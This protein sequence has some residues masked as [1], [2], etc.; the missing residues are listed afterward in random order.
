MKVFMMPT[1]SQAKADD[2]NS[3]N[4]IT[5]RLQK[6]FEPH[7]IEL[8][9]SASNAD[10]IA[11]HAGQTDGKTPCD[12][13]HIHG[14]YPT[15]LYPEM[16]WHWGA[17]A[18]VV[19][20]IKTAKVVT[21]PSQWVA[22]ILRRDMHINPQ[23]VGWAIDPDEWQPGENQGYV[24]WNK[25][26]VDRVCDPTPM[27]QL[28][29][30]SYKTL[31]L[32]TFGEN[33]TPNVRVVGRQPFEK[34]RDYIRNAAVYLAP[35][36]E[37]FGI[38]TL[39]ALAAGVPILAYDWGSNREIVQHGVTG[40][41]ASPGDIDGLQAG[42]E[43]CL[44]YRDTLSANAREA[45]R[46]Y[47]WDKV[48]SQFAMLYQNVLTP[49]K[50]EV[51]VSV[52]IP[53]HNYAQ[54]VGQAIESV[55]NQ[56]ASFDFEILV[57]NDRSSDDSKGVILDYRQKSP[58]VTYLEADY[59]NPADTR[60]YG[61][62]Q[63]QGEYIVCLDADDKLG[64]DAFLQTLADA[65]DTD[66][67]L[68]IVFTSIRMMDKDGNLGN[69]SQWP[70]GF[71]M[72]QQLAHHNQVP[73][74]CMFRREA[75]ERAGGYRNYLVPAED[76]HLWTMI[77][78]LGYK[79]HHLVEDG[80]FVYRLHE[81]SLS[82]TVRTGQR[83][84][85]DWLFYS[86]YA[87]DGL[88]PFAS[89]AKPAN[90][91]YSHPVRNY[92]TPEI[93]VIIPVGYAEHWKTLQHALDSVEGQTFRNWECIMVDD[94]VGTRPDLSAYP[95]AKIGFTGGGKGAGFARN[96]GVTQT[97]APYVTFLDADDYLHPQFLEH[98]LRAFK[99]TGRYVYTDWQSVNKAG[100]T[101][102]HATPEYSF[103][104]VFGKSSI[105]AV[106]VLIPRTT[107]DATGGFDE[108]MQAWED[109]DFFMKLAI[110]GYCGVRVPEPLFTYSY[111]TGKRRELGETI[112]SDL[113]A[114]LRERYGAYMTG[115]KMCDCN[116]PQPK[117]INLADLPQEDLIKVELL[118]GG[119]AAAPLNGRSGQSYGQR[120]RG[121]VF[122]V[123][124]S[125]MPDSRFAP[126]KQFEVQAQKT[127]VPPPPVLEFA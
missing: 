3:I 6:A 121:D 31:F 25:T 53:G 51:K 60:N 2:S 107:F 111:P 123:L 8:V 41:L 39:E 57:I 67:T 68:G 120:A 55:L 13:A 18:H 103:D 92:D 20:N 75:W 86:P 40:F 4:Q 24:L 113:K 83:R 71:D 116:T 64:S 45:A 114:L 99:R 88:H 85:P 27:V 80:W 100:E 16:E 122:Y 52:V 89:V 37:T 38:G 77:C 26:R 9:E 76:A 28:A 23:V 17:N 35:T 7:G 78:S 95:F 96:F 12:V 19:N 112:K 32:S 44:K 87:Q 79:A 127:V 10:L 70:H 110:N 15:A 1:P 126:Y 22:D 104:E 90:D 73:T 91:R 106:N 48:A 46:S 66:K 98:T 21:A 93:A 34:M 125:D 49:R 59:G 119:T 65:L 56:Q 74:C 84:E 97:T 82:S 42:L 33:V 101:E 30:K 69:I 105:H 58:R 36:K 54:Y 14:L 124:K 61:I 62:Q 94:S 108:S 29:A 109:V 47:T 81:N 63:A 115:E 50:Q 11:A 72:S 43:Y 118:V 5:L 117:V 102:Q